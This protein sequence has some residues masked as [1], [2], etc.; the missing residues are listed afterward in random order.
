MG[1]VEQAL[2]KQEAKYARLNAEAEAAALSIP[3]H[4]RAPGWLYV[5]REI[6]CIPDPAY[7]WNPEVV[8]AIQKIAPDIVPIFVRYHYQEPFD[9]G[10]YRIHTFGRH[11]LACINPDRRTGYADIN[12]AMPSVEYN[13]VKFSKPNQLEIIFKGGEDPRAKD[14]PGRYVPFDWDVYRFVKENYR[15]KNLQ[16]LK[17]QFIT[18]AF[19]RYEARKAKAAEEKAY[20]LKDFQKYAKRKLEQ[21]SELEAKE[22]FLGDRTPEKKPT[23]ALGSRGR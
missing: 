2:E 21:A 5:G 22:Y 16:Q 3:L 7:P 12:P 10:T 18:D 4:T 17:A 19:A 13:G 20:W 9:N 8:K 23:V 1:W 15:K 6:T 14:L 11:G